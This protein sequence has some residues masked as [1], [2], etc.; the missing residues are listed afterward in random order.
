MQSYSLTVLVKDKVDEKTRQGLLDD[1][2]KSFSS[3][4]K[5]DIWGVR[6]LAYPIKHADKAFYA[7][8]EF[9]GEPGA[10]ITLD[11]NIRLNEDIIRYLIVKKKVSKDGKVSR[12]SKGEDKESLKNA[13]SERETT[14]ENEEKTDSEAEIKES[15]KVRKAK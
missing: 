12:V 7:Y 13:E 6:S 14:Q 3:L 2:K 11:K 15:R 8:F 9:E 5:E 1:V 10:V 4:I